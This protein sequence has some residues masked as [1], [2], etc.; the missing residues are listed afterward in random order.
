MLHRLLL[1]SSVLCLLLTSANPVYAQGKNVVQSL[2]SVCQYL[3][4]NHAFN[5]VVLYTEKGKPL[6]KKAFGVVDYRTGTPLQ[7]N[8]AFNLASV[9]KQFIAMCIMMLQEKQQLRYDDA[10]NRYIPE[11]PYANITI[12]QLL[13]H[14][15]GLPEY[16]NLFI[17]TRGPLDTL[18]NDKLVALFARH[19]PSLD[20]S[21]GKKWQYSNTGYVLLAVIIQRV[22][23]MPVEQFIASNIAKPL[24][25]RDTYLYHVYLPAPANH[26]YGFEEVNGKRQI[27]DLGFMDGLTGDGNLYASAEDLLIWDQA[28][29]TEKLVKQSTLREALQ[30]V[31]L[32]NDS[33]Y[34]YGFG[35][36]ILKEN[37]V[38]AHTGGWAGFLNIICRD[39][40]HNRTLVVLSSG[41]DAT[42][43]RIARNIFEGK[44]YTAP[45]FQLINNVSVVDG[46]GTPARKAAVRLR[47][48][49]IIAVGDLTPNQGEA[50]V[51]G[52]GKMLVPGFIDTHSHLDRDLQQHPGAI[53]ALNQGITTIIVGQ[54]GESVTMDALEMQLKEK[55]VA[56][57]MA[58]YTGHTTLRKK[59]MGNEGLLRTAS[60]AETNAMRQL[61][62]AELQRGS[63]G[64]STGLEYEGAHFASRE[65]V[66]ALAKTAA[67]YKGRYVSHVRS[68]DVELESAIEE[69]I[70]IGREA[71]LPVQL[72]HAKIAMRSKWGTAPALIAQLERARQQG[73][74]ITSDCYPYEFWYSTL[75][76]LFPKTDFNNLQSATFA[77]E[78]TVDP[79]A[80]VVYPFPAVKEYEGKTISAIAALRNES[81]AQTLIS[82]IALADA[83]EK[84]HPGTD[85][86]GIIGKSMT[87]ADISTLLSWPNTN[88]CSDGGAGGH[89]RSHGAFTRVLG[90][91]VR[92]KQ[93]LSFEHAI[94][95]MTALAAANTG[96]GNRGVIAP[97]YFA[98]LVLLDPDTVKDNATIEQPDA[99]SD[100][101]NTVWVNGVM[102]YKNKQSSGKYPGMLLK[103]QQQ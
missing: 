98:D 103:K 30:P 61:L 26:V 93:L 99:L 57:N 46:T 4:N 38:Y 92:E 10:I 89:P 76:V 3:Y 27:N 82:L 29:Y 47:D 43:M 97:G 23:G 49:R 62:A 71:K 94:Y 85:A 88:I 40:Q 36:G 96:I 74:N 2:D 14:T 58:T 64:L 32:N 75:R 1:I 91:Y 65:E 52:Q 67:Q 60:A 78:Q 25:L 21:P 59:V 9:T 81:P 102:V 100:G 41:S 17:N 19:K 83:Y 51:D 69:L 84:A 33:T 13:T 70:S 5:G 54:D 55:P 86:E 39:V 20:F 28:L 56:V 37:A 63:L 77:V 95:K 68:E 42:A 12:R 11:L 90:H 72:S 16:F 22:S 34:P 31:K 8:A 87:D 50:V 35:W 7:T 6:Y 45:A 44:P 73:V 24:G 79:V 18:T 66:V 101:I 53:P 15:S 80:S 48:D